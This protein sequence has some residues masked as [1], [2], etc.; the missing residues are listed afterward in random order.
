MCTVSVEEDV[1]VLGSGRP[2]GYTQYECTLSARELYTLKMAKIKSFMLC[3]FYTILKS[4][5]KER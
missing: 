3:I 2:D 4:C 1:K 5:K